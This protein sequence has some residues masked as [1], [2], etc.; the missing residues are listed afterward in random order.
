MNTSILVKAGEVVTFILLMFG[1]FF[2]NIAPPES[3]DAK[4][5]V[6][7][8]SVALVCLLLFVV[9]L[10]QHYDHEKTKKLWFIAS[11]TF[12]ISALL[13]A[14]NYKN[15]LDTL[16]FY[17]PPDEPI[18]RYIGGVTM[19]PDMVKEKEKRGL[20]NAQIVHE[21]GAKEYLGRVWTE[22][23]RQEAKHRLI[24]TYIAFVTCF[25]LTM[26]CLIEGV[27]IKANW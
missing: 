17:Y 10:A 21:M 3:D 13:F 25:A 26:F 18:A 1:G 7:V 16:T 8:T 12:F 2:I 15:N 4:F 11:C 19:L 14:A 23:S 24:T 20:T 6:G 27:R 22:E 9:S 5:A